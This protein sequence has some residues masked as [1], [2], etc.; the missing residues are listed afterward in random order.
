MTT[1]TTPGLNSAIEELRA[2]VR[3]S[4]VG[5]GE[6]KYD[7]ARHVWNGMID[8][9]PGIIVRCAGERDVAATVQAARR[10]KLP[11]AVRGGGHNVAGSGVCDGGVV[12]DLSG[13][14][15]VEVDPAARTVRVQGGATLGDIDPATQAHGLAVPVGVVSETGIA[16]LALGGGLGWLRRKYGLTSDNLLS[17]RVVLA[18]G[19]AVTASPEENVD[20]FWAL[21]GG[22]G[23]FGVVTSFEFRAYPLGPEVTMLA[24]FHPFE[25]AER[26]LRFFRE[27]MESAPDELSSFAILGGVPEAEL[28]P[29]QAHGRDTLIFAAMWSG[30]PAEGE[31]VVEP[32]KNFATP[33]ADLS[34]RWSYL[35]VQKFFDE[36][37]PAGGRYY[38]K[39]QYLDALT[40]EGI[41]A[42]ITHAERRPSKA[43]TV[44]LWHLGGA[45]KSVAR[46]A[47]PVPQRDARYLIG[48]EANWT[49]PSTDQSNMAWARDL[50]AET[51]RLSPA[52]IY[53]NFP[54][55][56]E[57]G[58]DLVRAAYGDNY[59][60][61][62]QIKA[63]YDP[64]NLF[65]INQNI[66]PAS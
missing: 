3:G 50:Y 45:I 1:E 17:A 58:E 19:S 9:R 36:D 25:E 30:D 11:L 51:Q 56:G 22:G 63:K 15:K 41:A 37:Y 2:Q 7:E 48:I 6:A 47:T 13:M 18:D 31:R 65:R 49:D 27:Y 34:G 23:N 59:T 55:F 10:H 42:L 39:S 21:R 28:F 29:A 32:L 62:T 43:S 4:L 66:K 33:L 8:R 44:D 5:P 26:G 16:G 20:L 52:S 40:D 60:R 24:V 54:G 14:R 57:E 53:V 12:I 64:D 61:L 46:D 38:W 35:D